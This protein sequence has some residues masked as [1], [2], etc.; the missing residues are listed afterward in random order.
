M[1]PAALPIENVPSLTATRP[2]PVIVVPDLSG[3]EPLVKV[4]V[5]LRLPV[6]AVIALKDPTTKLAQKGIPHAIYPDDGVYIPTTIQSRSP[7][8]TDGVEDDHVPDTPPAFV[9]GK[10]DMPYVLPADVDVET[11]VDAQYAYV[12]DAP[13][14]PFVPFVPALPVSPVAPVAPCGP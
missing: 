14:D 6:F 5:L 10:E 7:L 2:D 8:L 11:V 13:L 9:V 1:F 4:P 3:D 12:V